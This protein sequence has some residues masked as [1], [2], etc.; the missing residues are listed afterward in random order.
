MLYFVCILLY[1]HIV[2]QTAIIILLHGYQDAL[3]INRH[4]VIRMHYAYLWKTLLF[5]RINVAET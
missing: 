5:V 3:T 4:F 1:L 2:V